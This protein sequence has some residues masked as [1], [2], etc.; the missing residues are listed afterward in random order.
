[1]IRREKLKISWLS[2]ICLLHHQEQKLFNIIVQYYTNN[3][4]MPGTVYNND[5]DNLSGSR[6]NKLKLENTLLA[7]RIKQWW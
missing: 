6:S 4:F 3:Q 1:M 7:K 5:N 2:V